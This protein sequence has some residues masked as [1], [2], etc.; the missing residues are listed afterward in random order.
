MLKTG[1]NAFSILKSEFSGLKLK[2]IS[3]YDKKKREYTLTKSS[4]KKL[5]ENELL[6]S[7]RH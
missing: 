7:D 2:S 5:I 4:S 1:S 3:K 6:K